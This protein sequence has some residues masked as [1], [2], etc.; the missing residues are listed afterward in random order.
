MFSQEKSGLIYRCSYKDFDE[1]IQEQG[2]DAA[3]DRVLTYSTCEMFYYFEDFSYILDKQKR[4][5]YEQR[6]YDEF[7]AKFQQNKYFA[8]IMKFFNEAMDSDR[9]LYIENKDQHKGTVLLIT[10]QTKITTIIRDYKERGEFIREFYRCM[11]KEILLELVIGEIKE[12]VIKRV[13]GERY[14]PWEVEQ[15]RKRNQK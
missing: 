10:L 12:Y 11:P 9:V 3:L 5:E 8:S 2:I 14:R 4:E 6:F 7:C 1:L 15:I 13:Q